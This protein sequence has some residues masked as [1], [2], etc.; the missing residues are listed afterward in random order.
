MR[1]QQIAREMLEKHHYFGHPLRPGS[2]SRALASLMRKGLVEKRI[3]LFRP[4][5]GRARA[6]DRAADRM[7]SDNVPRLQ[8]PP[9]FRFCELLDFFTPYPGVPDLRAA[10]L[11][12]GYP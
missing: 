9:P 11:A 12:R 7:V 3:G 1:P 2:I 5:I 10:R 4:T 6:G 8:L